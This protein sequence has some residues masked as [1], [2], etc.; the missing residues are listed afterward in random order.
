MPDNLDAIKLSPEKEKAIVSDICQQIETAL[1]DR[2]SMEDRWIKWIKQYEEILPESK[3]FPWEG[4]SNLSVPLSPTT[5]ETIHAREVNTLFSIR[6]YIQVRPKKKDVPPENC[7]KIERFLDQIF[8]NTLKFYQKGSNWLLEK[9]KM[10][11]GFLKVFWKK[12]KK[13]INKTEFRDIDQ[14][15]ADVIPIEDLIFPVNASDIQ[16]SSFVAHR[17]RRP[18]SYLMRKQ[19]LGVYQNIDKLKE[20]VETSTASSTGKDVT[21][22]KEEAEKLIRTSPETLK[23]IEFYEVYFSYDVDEDGYEEPTIM[24]VHAKSKTILRWIYFPY[25]HG[26]IPFI[27]AKYIERI[28]RLYG[29]GILEISEHI[30]EG[31]NT[32]FNQTIDN[33]TLANAKCFK[34]RKSA[35]K[36]MGKVYPGKVFWLDDPDTDL[37]EFMLG[38]VHQSSFAI[39][40]LLREYHERRTKVTDYTTGRESAIV[41]SRATATGT[42]AL[43]QESGRHFDLVINNSRQALAE[44]A[45]QIIELY[46]QYDPYKI[47]YIDGEDSSLPEGLTI[48]NLRDE[49]EFYCTAT[50][51]TV[52]KE[53]EKQVNLI[54]LQQLSGIFQQMLQLLMMVFNPQVQLPEEIRGFVVNM[55]KVYYKMA[56]DLVRSFEKI[57]VKQYLPELP[58][59]VKQAYGQTQVGQEEMLAKVLSMAG[60][61]NDREGSPTAPTGLTMP[62]GMGAPDTGVTSPSVEGVTRPSGS[63]P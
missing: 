16:N 32:V 33:A 23:E 56:E 57:D 52:N 20:Q 48:L 51:L 28:G 49:Y 17:I 59:I 6:P 46:A 5:V 54:L 39:H 35:K 7:A 21:K 36:D 29:K 9:D 10:G 24:T 31:I 47:F 61:M 41:G 22:T 38:E 25:N 40:N 55:V 8:L 15:G 4:C 53:I 3:N 2:A 14:I 27:P 45:Y 13:K 37:K 19:K 12:D 26:Q 60:G 34:G 58:D 11:T 63:L 18:L 42:L 30:Q 44:T 1:S 62:Q 50:S 43:L